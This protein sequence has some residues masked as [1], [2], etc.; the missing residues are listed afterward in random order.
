M[1]NL[2][3]D[4]LNE[5]TVIYAKFGKD[6]FNTSKVISCKTKWPRFFG[7]AKVKPTYFFAGDA[8]CNVM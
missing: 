6:L 7:P 1:G 3:H 8:N 5:E 2:W 4:V